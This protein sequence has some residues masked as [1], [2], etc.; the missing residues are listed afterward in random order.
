MK[1]IY[2][3]EAG[4]TGR[5]L[6]P[7]QPHH[8]IAAVL[9]DAVQVPEVERIMRGLAAR[10]CG[11]DGLVG[12]IE[13]HGYEIRAGRGAF[14]GMA[15]ERRIE[16]MRDIVDV[17]QA[18]KLA[19]GYV[20]IDKHK[21]WSSKHPHEFAFMFLVE[22]IQ[23]VLKAENRLGLIIADEHKDVEQKLIE[24]LDKYKQFDTN[25]GYRPTKA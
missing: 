19:V 10:H 5:K 15:V 25:W 18:Q 2:L 11:H 12:E 9:V 24:D 16:V 1:F 17:I 13:F 21:T 22:R 23:D 4:N 14:K 8:L 20:S 7:D 6:D 3:D